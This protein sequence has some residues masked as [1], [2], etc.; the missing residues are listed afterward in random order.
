[1]TMQ[2]GTTKNKIDPK[3]SA[4]K[5]K[6]VTPTPSD[7][8]VLERPTSKT[9]TLCNGSL[10]DYLIPV[11]STS[12]LKNER[13]LK[14]GIR[15]IKGAQHIFV[16]EQGDV[17]GVSLMPIIFARG[18]FY[19]NDPLLMEYLDTTELNAENGGK[20]FKEVNEERDAQE[21]IDSRK[22]IYDAVHMAT[23]SLKIGEV[24]TLARALKMKNVTTSKDSVVRFWLI[25]FAENNPQEFME[26]HQSP[27][28][29][30]VELAQRGLETGFII[31]QNRRDVAWRGGNVF[32]TI[33]LGFDNIPVESIANF[34]LTDDG[35]TVAKALAEMLEK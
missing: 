30:V 29:K 17:G 23:S 28:P 6:T 4:N 22:L 31:I 10:G 18:R 2:A 24:R 7:T 16:D 35:A 27:L 34:L 5:A 19:T 3:G 1:M 21:A 8:K 15:F 26:M 32:Y 14:R 13:G 12:G 33:P 25:N 11:R 20:I 9:Y